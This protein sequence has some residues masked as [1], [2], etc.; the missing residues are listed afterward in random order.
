MDAPRNCSL[1]CAAGEGRGGG[2]TDIVMRNRLAQQRARRLRKSSTDTERVLWYHLRRRQLAGYRFRRQVPVG[3]YIVDFACLEAKLIVEV[4]GSQHQEFGAYDRNRDQ[5]LRRCG[6]VVLRFWDNDV[7][8]QTQ[9]VLEAISN[10]LTSLQRTRL[11][12]QATELR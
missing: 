10:A 12:P 4:D 8:T 5:Y 6:L 2:N 11:L 7:L 1:P 9:S 3:S